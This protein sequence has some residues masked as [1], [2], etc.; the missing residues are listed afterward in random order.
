M[1]GSFP[2]S[3]LV[4]LRL[5]SLLGPMGADIV[6]ESFHHHRDRVA[7]LMPSVV[8]VTHRVPRAVSCRAQA[9]NIKLKLLHRSSQTIPV[10]PQFLCRLRLI[11]SQ[12]SQDDPDKGLLE[13]ANRVCIWNAIRPHLHKDRF[14]LDFEVA[15]Y[16]IPG[17]ARVA[18]VGF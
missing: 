11:P 4:G 10:H 9:S 12:L 17:Q 14:K 16:C 6:M 8:H 7:Q 13:L 3:P 1:F 18:I 2:P 5:Q 15:H